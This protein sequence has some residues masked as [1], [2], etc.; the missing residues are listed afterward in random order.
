MLNNFKL[1][2][3]ILIKEFSVSL[4]TASSNLSSWKTERAILSLR[5]TPAP[6][7]PTIT[8]GLLYISRKLNVQPACMC[9]TPNSTWQ[10]S[11]GPSLLCTSTWYSATN[12]GGSNTY[13]PTERRCYKMGG[14]FPRVATVL[15]Q[16]QNAGEDSVQVSIGCFGRINVHYQCTK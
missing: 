7:D 1:L 3:F 4:T 11:H 2:V 13:N 8:S 6:L 10:Q 5:W 9:R 15:K 14:M 16:L 12:V